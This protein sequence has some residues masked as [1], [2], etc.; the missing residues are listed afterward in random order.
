MLSF[1]GA[2]PEGSAVRQDMRSAITTPRAVRVSA[3]ASAELLT[4]SGWFGPARVGCRY[5]THTNASIR[6]PCTSHS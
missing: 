4:V 1:I 5:S 2:Y 3:T 6:R